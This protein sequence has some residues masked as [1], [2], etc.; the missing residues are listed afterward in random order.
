MNNEQ[1]YIL[2]SPLFSNLL[3]KTA[4]LYC[5]GNQYLFWLLNSMALSIAHFHGKYVDAPTAPLAT[6]LT[7]A[8]VLDAVT[9]NDVF[10]E[11]DGGYI[12]LED[13]KVLIV[14]VASSEYRKMLSI[15]RRSC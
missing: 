14:E 2:I 1:I 3:W 11:H 15:L 4:F 13:S 5:V 12:T 6:N 10:H 7:A 8:L 9:I